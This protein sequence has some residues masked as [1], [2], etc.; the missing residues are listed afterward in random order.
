MVS[1]LVTS[2]EPVGDEGVIGVVQRGIISDFGRTAIRICTLSKKLVDGSKGV[3]LN[4]IV[5]SVDDKLRDLRLP[6]KKSQNLARQWR[7]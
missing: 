5:G 3:G 6:G 1:D 4:S 7:S 2:D